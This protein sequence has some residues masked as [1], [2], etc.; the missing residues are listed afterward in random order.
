MRIKIRKTITWMAINLQCDNK[1]FWAVKTIVFS[2]MFQFINSIQFYCAIRLEQRCKG[3]KNWW[4]FQI[5]KIHARHFTR[6]DKLMLAFD[7]ISIYGKREKLG[8]YLYI[9]IK[10]NKLLSKKRGKSKLFD[11]LTEMNMSIKCIVYFMV[12]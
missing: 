8:S 10:F 1:L 7:Y 4:K 2:R 5:T 6:D 3:I 12:L 9:S 11:I